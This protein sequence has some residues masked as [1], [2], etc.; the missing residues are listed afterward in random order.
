MLSC[1]ITESPGQ[2]VRWQ[3]DVERHYDVTTLLNTMTKLPPR[4]ESELLREC[5]LPVWDGMA[6]SVRLFLDRPRMATRT[7]P[8]S[9]MVS[10]PEKNVS[11]ADDDGWM[12]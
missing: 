1:S 7:E 10:L 2:S 4:H 6:Y 5:V 3:R 8:V 12:K 9:V 11:R